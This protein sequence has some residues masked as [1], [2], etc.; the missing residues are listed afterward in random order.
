MFLPETSTFKWCFPLDDEPN[1]LD[2]KMGGHH[3]I[4]NQKETVFKGFNWMIPNLYLGNGCFTKYS[5]KNWFLRVPGKCVKWGQEVF[6]GKMFELMR[7]VMYPPGSLTSPPEN[8]PK[9]KR[10]RSSSN[11]HSFFQGRAVK[12]RGCNLLILVCS[13]WRCDFMANEFAIH[14]HA[15][16][17]QVC[18]LWY[19]FAI[20]MASEDVSFESLVFWM[21]TLLIPH[22]IKEGRSEMTSMFFWKQ[23]IRHICHSYGW[24]KKSCTTWDV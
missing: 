21:F 15:N 23:S 3:Q 8:R 13:D 24:W 6:F 20:W 11:Q 12:L 1:P 4:S 18:T 7:D 9:H 2:E 17:I 16:A 5:F 19:V 14:N 10:K 22:T